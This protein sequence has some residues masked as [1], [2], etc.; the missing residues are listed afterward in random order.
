[1]NAEEARFLLSSLPQG[2]PFPSEGEVAEALALARED[3]ALAAWLGSERAL[4]LAV[5]AKLGQFHPPFDLRAAILAGVRLSRP[6]PW[7][8][9]SFTVAA[10][11]AIALSGAV[12]VVLNETRHGV[13]STGVANADLVE[14]RE[15]MVKNIEQLDRFDHASGELASIRD[16]LSKNGGGGDFEAPGPLLSRSTAGCRLLE[17]RAHRVTLVC[18]RAEGS[19]DGPPTAHL[20]VLEDGEEFSGMEREPI[21]DENHDWATAVWRD[22]GKTYLLVSKEGPAGL[23]RLLGLA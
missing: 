2:E 22:G 6:R 13:V 18:F 15:T 21:L 23:R 5:A 12:L 3:P 14:F 20:V 19:P 11:A 16:W 8:R 9:R 1:M 10:A 4:D 17:W 7:W